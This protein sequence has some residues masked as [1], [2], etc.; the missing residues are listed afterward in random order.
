MSHNSIK[1]L[2]RYLCKNIGLQPNRNLFKTYLR[3]EFE[4]FKNSQ[5]KIKS[6]KI[7]LINN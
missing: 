1:L 5:I 7:E 4:K 3:E 6:E 2:Y